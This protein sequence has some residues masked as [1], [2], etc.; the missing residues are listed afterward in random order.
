MINIETRF[1]TNNES[2]QR[3]EKIIPEGIMVHSL[4]TSQSNVEPVFNYFNQWSTRASVQP[5]CMR[6]EFATLPYTTK[7]WHCGGSGNSNL[8]SFEI[9]EPSDLHTNLILHK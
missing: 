2:F 9:L 8:I 3:D 7:A 6:Q 4:G 1:L 5:W